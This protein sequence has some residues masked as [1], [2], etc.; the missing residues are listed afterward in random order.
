MSVNEQVKLPYAGNDG[1]D[2]RR[3]SVGL[4]PVTVA[5]TYTYY[6]LQKESIALCSA[7]KMQ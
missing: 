4:L 2:F 6:L 7:T 3:P 5:T 1:F